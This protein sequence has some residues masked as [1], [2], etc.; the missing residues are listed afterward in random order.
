MNRDALGECWRK[1]SLRQP[2][3]KAFWALQLARPVSVAA[4]AVSISQVEYLELVKMNRQ[5]ST[6]VE[7]GTGGA[8][9][10]CISHEHL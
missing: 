2:G 1:P 10:R 4:E 8:K 7:E 3:P 6:V 9:L 5:R